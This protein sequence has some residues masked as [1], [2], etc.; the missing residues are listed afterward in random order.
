[1]TGVAYPGQ[2]FPAEWA[3]TGERGDSI[4]CAVSAPQRGTLGVIVT[5]ES[6]TG[7]GPILFEA[8]N[9]PCG[10]LGDPVRQM[11]IASI[12]SGTTLTVDSARHQIV[13][14]DANDIATDGS[15][16]LTLSDRATQ[17]L[18]VR[19]CDA[20]Q[21]VCVTP[22]APLGLGNYAL[23]QIDTRIREG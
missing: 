20:I 11:M 16:L 7:F 14:V 9:E 8:Y 5:I 22:A 10:A 21:C 15:Y 13:I 4:C 6:P 18:E 12:P 17:W 19:D 2:I 23:V 1:M 3:A